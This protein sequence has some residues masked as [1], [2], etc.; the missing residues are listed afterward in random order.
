[1][2]NLNQP[3]TAKVLD[4]ELA[5]LLKSIARI[6]GMAENQIEEAAR[7]LLERDDRLAA[8]VI[9]RDQEVD[10]LEADIQQKSCT[11]SPCRPGGRRSESGGQRHFRRVRLRNAS[12]ITPP[13]RRS[14][15][16]AHTKP[17][18]RRRAPWSA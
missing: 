12:P 9:K 5:E 10:R 13:T 8:E 2:P 1:M 18:F 14:V 6:G 7:A 3:H 11:C 15:D 17:A 4:R 16:G